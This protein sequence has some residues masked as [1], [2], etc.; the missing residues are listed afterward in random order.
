MSP[1]GKVIVI[2]LSTQ[3]GQ[4]LV[5]H[6][7]IS[8]TEIKRINLEYDGKVIFLNDGTLVATDNTHIRFFDPRTWQQ[9]REIA[10]G[11]DFSAYELDV[12]AKDE[13][14]AVADWN[15]VRVWRL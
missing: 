12:S 5:I 9:V 4:G 11:D 14:L 10:G 2:S 6:D 15:G 1:D 13:F 8:G 7:S 3:E